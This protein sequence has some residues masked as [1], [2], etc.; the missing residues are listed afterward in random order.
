MSEQKS[1]I[2][3]IVEA[4]DQYRAERRKEILIQSKQAQSPS[5]LYRILRWLT[6]NGGTILLVLILIFTQNVW[7]APLQSVLNAPGPSATTINYQGRLASSE[8][9]PLDEQVDLKFAIYD[10]LEDGSMIWPEI[11]L[12]EEHKEVPV[13]DGLFTVVLGEGMVDGNSS[14]GIDSSV[15]NGDRWLQVWVE[16]EILYPR[17]QIHSVPIAGMALTVPDGAITASKLASDAIITAQNGHPQYS[18]PITLSGI[19]ESAISF[20]GTEATIDVSV[21]SRILVIAEGGLSILEGQGSLYAGVCINGESARRIQ[22]YTPETGITNFEKWSWVS[23]VPV[24]EGSYT[25]SL[26]ARGKSGLEVRW[27]MPTV[28]LIAIPGQ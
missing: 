12:P 25:F 7:A 21:P 1:F 15:W 23:I 10:A 19:Y 5:H 6:P 4:I 26:C 8:G 22:N 28:S 27:F 16:D 17:E 13:S 3:H 9:T 11:G 20:P 18:D 14:N 2:H 24:E